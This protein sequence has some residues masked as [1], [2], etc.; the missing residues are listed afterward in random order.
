MLQW[1]P[2]GSIK[3]MK[4]PVKQLADDSGSIISEEEEGRKSEYRDDLLNRQTYVKTYM[5]GTV[6][7]IYP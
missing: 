3:G 2:T 1:F 4:A 6:Q 7:S 5:M